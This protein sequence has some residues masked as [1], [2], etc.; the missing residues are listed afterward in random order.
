MKKNLNMTKPL[1][2]KFWHSLDPLLHRGSTSCTKCSY[3]NRLPYGNKLS[4]CAI[5]PVWY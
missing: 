5:Q 1:T 3:R 4:S 2:E